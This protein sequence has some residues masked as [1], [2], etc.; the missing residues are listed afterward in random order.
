MYLVD[1][2]ECLE[3]LIFVVDI[4]YLRIE[5]EGYVGAHS[6]EIDCHVNPILP[7]SNNPTIP[8]ADVCK[9]TIIERKNVGELYMYTLFEKN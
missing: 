9:K 2:N 5:Y 1:E 7:E 3:F 6:R 4:M 8:V